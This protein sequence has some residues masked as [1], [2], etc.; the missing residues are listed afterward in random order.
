MSITNCKE[1]LPGVIAEIGVDDKIILIDFAGIGGDVSLFG[2]IGK[3]HD[4]LEE[5]I[6]IFCL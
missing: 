2:S 4:V 6:I 3:P 1:M 5:V